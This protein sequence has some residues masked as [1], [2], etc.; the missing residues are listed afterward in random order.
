VI[1][2]NGFPK[3]AKIKFTNGTSASVQ[4][5]AVIGLR[6]QGEYVRDGTKS[7]PFYRNLLNKWVAIKA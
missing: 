3:K 4:I 1:I 7:Q 6:I 5:I 2:L